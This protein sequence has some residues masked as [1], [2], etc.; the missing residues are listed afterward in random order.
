MYP[1]EMRTGFNNEREEMFMRRKILKPVTEV[2][3]LLLIVTESVPLQ[4]GTNHE[5]LCGAMQNVYD[6]YADTDAQEEGSHQYNDDLQMGNVNGDE[7]INIKDS[8]LLK[9]YLAG[10]DVEFSE[11]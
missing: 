11:P 10:W 4:T 3:L 8:A 9:R 1:W 2:M 6:A 5:I 7:E